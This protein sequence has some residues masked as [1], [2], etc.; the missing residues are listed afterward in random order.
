M[1]AK[2]TKQYSLIY[3]FKASKAMWL[4]SDTFTWK[5]EHQA[6]N[7]Q[8]FKPEAKKHIN[9]LPEMKPS[10]CDEPAP[11]E[12]AHSIR[13]VAWANPKKS[14]SLQEFTLQRKM[15]CALLL[16]GCARGRMLEIGQRMRGIHSLA[17]YTHIYKKYSLCSERL[18]ALSKPS[19]HWLRNNQPGQPRIIT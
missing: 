15:A 4:H 18:I 14:G 12:S 11:D 1:V 17:E 6:L 9:N 10:R 2:P 13:K 16:K 7:S 5:T 3:S 8:I 19:M